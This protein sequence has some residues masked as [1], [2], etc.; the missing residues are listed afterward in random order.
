MELPFGNSHLT[1][2]PADPRLH[3]GADTAPGPQ[4]EIY[5][6]VSED[7]LAKGFVRPVRTTYIH[8]DGCGSRTRMGLKL[9]ETYAREPSF[10]GSTYCM[11][12]KMHKPVSEFIWDRT[13]ERV[14][15]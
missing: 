11:K 12:C 4:N 8:I 10:Y 14:G 1:T 5:L 6:V 9:S 15:S 3:K 7:E 2:D 13:N